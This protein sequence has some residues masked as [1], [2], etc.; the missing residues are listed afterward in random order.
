M[1][2][3]PTT[4]RMLRSKRKAEDD[5]DYTAQERAV[6]FEKQKILQKQ[7]QV[8]WQ[9]ADLQRLE[10]E[11][12]IQPILDDMHEF[13]CEEKAIQHEKEG[14]HHEIE[15]LKHEMMMLVHE[16]E[17]LQHEIEKMKYEGK[18]LMQQIARAQ[19]RLTTLTLQNQARASSSWL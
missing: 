11:Q 13:L 1:Y 7:L 18:I 12:Q 10:H 16:R 19:G 8:M 17:K 9:S 3:Q 14:I 6:H 5:A 2:M 4:K 15:A